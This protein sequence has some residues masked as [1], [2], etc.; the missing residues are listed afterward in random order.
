MKIKKILHKIDTLSFGFKSTFLF[1]IIL[2]GMIS[3]IV[4][5]QISSYT[6]KNDYD[7]LF[8]KRTKSIIRLEAIKD[9]YVVNINETL[10]DM[11]KNIINHEQSMEVITLAK[12]LIN[13][14]WSTYLE[15]TDSKKYQTSWINKIIKKIFI[16]GK[17]EHNIILQQRLITNIQKRKKTINIFLNT[18]FNSHNYIENL[19]L[20]IEEVNY[21]ID[22]LSIYI[23]S[24]INYDLSMTIQEK[25]DSDKIFDI[26]SLILNISIVVV[27]IFSALLSAFIITNFKRLHF[28]L[29]GDVLKK[30]KALEQLN[31]SLEIKIKK[32]VENSRKKDTLMFQQARLASMGEMIANIAHQWRQPLSSLM[33]IVQGL[34]T[35][36]ELEKL[37]PEI[38][39]ARVKDAIILGENMS[40]TLENFQN[41]FKPTKTKESFSLTT[42]IKHSFTLSKY[43]LEKNKIKID[44]HAPEEIRLHSYYNELS[45]VFLNIIANAKD[46]LN[47]IEG[48]KFIDIVVK[49]VHNK[50]YIYIVDNGGGINE[51]T[52]PHIFE[53]YFTTKYKS[54]GTGLGLYM[55]QQIIEKHMQGTIRCKNVCYTIKDN[56][57]EHCTLF[58]IILPNIKSD[59]DDT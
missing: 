31:T 19:P 39:D 46:A 26:L 40:L 6:I 53:P 20:Y 50:I 28:A 9:I 24:L 13:K 17:Q 32:E 42:C 16:L 7:L 54:T 30:T 51:D 49:E 4:L 47:S 29:E 3:I 35:K 25:R 58:T 41:F 33:M 57:F 56:K 44:I 23:T 37:T 34:Q 55:S 52:L 22:S 8:E 18:I 36:M 15:M 21:E 45:H 5:S 38:L 27:F 2:G 1:F 11:Q 14:D 43:I 59:T 10:D 48:E 12:Q